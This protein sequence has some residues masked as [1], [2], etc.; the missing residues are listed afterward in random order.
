MGREQD[1][2]RDPRGKPVSPNTSNL[3]PGSGTSSCPW[4]QDNQLPSPPP[5]E[6]S[7]LTLLPEK[8][9]GHPQKGPLA[10]PSPPSPPLPTLPNAAGESFSPQ[11]LSLPRDHQPSRP[12]RG[13]AVKLESV[14]PASPLCELQAPA[15][16][17]C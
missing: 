7:A 5:V 14:S 6:P 16:P 11:V 3:T 4:M 17:G 10:A 12:G 13:P 15:E 9:L 1:L 8:R 2:Y